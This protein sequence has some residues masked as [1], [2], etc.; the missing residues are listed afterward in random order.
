MYDVCE[1]QGCVEQR[2]L[3]YTNICI[4]LMILFV[5]GLGLM[6]VNHVVFPQTEGNIERG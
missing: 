1:G 4:V 6:Y 2:R 5:C 3:S